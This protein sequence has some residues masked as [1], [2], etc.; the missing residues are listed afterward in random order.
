VRLLSITFHPHSSAQLHRSLR[1]VRRP[2]AGSHPSTAH[3]STASTWH[4][5]SAQSLPYLTSMVRSSSGL[6]SVRF[7]SSG[8]EMLCQA[9]YERC[10]SKGAS[11]RFRL[12]GACSDHKLTAT[13]LQS[14]LT[15]CLARKTC[16][17]SKISYRSSREPYVCLLMSFLHKYADL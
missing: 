7:D 1:L 11:H 13:L 14:F 2:S 3:V 5:P 15:K 16:R 12:R 10:T 6:D 4:R 9:V 8:C 17:S